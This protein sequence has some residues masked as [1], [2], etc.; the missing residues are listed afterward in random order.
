MATIKNTTIMNS[1]ISQNIFKSDFYRVI[2]ENYY[3]FYCD[4]KKKCEDFSVNIIKNIYEKIKI[5]VNTEKISIR[6][7]RDDIY[8]IRQY[9]SH[10]HTCCILNLL[11]LGE[12]YM[13]NDS[14]LIKKYWVKQ[15]EGYEVAIKKN[16]DYG[17]SFREHGFMGV[18]VRLS[19]KVKR[20]I[21]ITT[22]RK[23]NFEAQ[24]DTFKDLANYCVMGIFLLDENEDNHNIKFDKNNKFQ[25][26]CNYCASNKH[27]LYSNHKD[28]QN[29]CFKVLECPV[30]KD[31]QFYSFCNYCKE[32]G[33]R[34]YYSFENQNQKKNKNQNQN[35]N[36]N[37]NC[38]KLYTCPKLIQ[39]YKRNYF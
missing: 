32:Y 13:G 27:D 21:N 5:L 24:E 19:D 9:L 33:H 20:L 23:I 22:N 28:N 36:T 1:E 31:T 30:L 3:L 4:L 16:Q 35:Q 39:K 2:Q 12:D 29:N 10:I 38:K 11:K 14:E 26:T 34:I 18:L 6:I 17:D 15:Y 7:S 8:H 25:W 37:E